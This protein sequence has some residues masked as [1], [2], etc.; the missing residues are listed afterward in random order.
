MRR[1]AHEENPALLEGLRRPGMM[2]IYAPAHRRRDRSIRVERLHQ[3]SDSIR[4]GHGLVVFALKNLEFEAAKSEW[5]RNCHRRPM[6]RG[7]DGGIRRIPSIVLDIDDQPFHRRRV[8]HQWDV[9]RPSDKAFAAIGTD[10][11]PS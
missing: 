10:R 3:F 11:K 1:I 6:R 5:Q 9:Q 4:L 8:A 2:P 7:V